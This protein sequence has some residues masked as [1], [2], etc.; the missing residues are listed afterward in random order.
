MFIWLGRVGIHA[1]MIIHD[2]IEKG[3]P[4]YLFCMVHFVLT[5]FCSDM[6]S[7][8]SFVMFDT[9]Y[10]NGCLREK[11]HLKR[12]TVYH[13][14]DPTTMRIDTWTVRCAHIFSTG[15]RTVYIRTQVFLQICRL[16]EE[17]GQDILVWVAP[18]ALQPDKG[19]TKASIITFAAQAGIL[20]P[21]RMLH[22]EKK[23]GEAMGLE[24]R[25]IHLTNVWQSSAS[26]VWRA[27]ADA[28]GALRSFFIHMYWSNIL[29]CKW[30]SSFGRRNLIS[31]VGVTSGDSSQFK[32]KYS[33]E[34]LLPPLV[35][36]CPILSN[37]NQQLNI[38][39]STFPTSSIWSVWLSTWAALR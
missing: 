17:S 11:M 14:V 21:C 19:C 33:L 29:V 27:A 2:Y 3:K 7:N 37:G 20:P 12:C 15:T 4:L 38:V 23:Q 35:Q 25:W 28:A 9:P 13:T 5:S 16:S 8:I 32:Q 6:T 39:L 22:P 31:T 10:I 36:C 34:I 1:Y 26:H 18:E 30:L 24:R